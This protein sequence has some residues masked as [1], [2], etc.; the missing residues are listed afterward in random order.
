MGSSQRKRTWGWQYHR[1]P[2]WELEFATP[3]PQSKVNLLLRH[4][5]PEEP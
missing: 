3:T 4:I 1:G 2:L 5:L